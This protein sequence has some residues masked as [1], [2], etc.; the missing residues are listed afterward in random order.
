MKPFNDAIG[1]IITFGGAMK[2]VRK[3][4]AKKDMQAFFNPLDSKKEFIR[5]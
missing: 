4:D 3:K 5:P 1:V 2:I